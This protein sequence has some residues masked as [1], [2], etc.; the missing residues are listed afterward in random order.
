MIKLKRLCLNLLKIIKMRIKVIYILK[1]VAVCLLTS[2]WSHTPDKN[3][4]EVSKAIVKALDTEVDS[5]EEEKPTI[6]QYVYMDRTGCL[7]LKQNCYSFND[8]DQVILA[9]ETANESSESSLDLKG[10]R[11][12][13][14]RISVKGQLKASDLDYCCCNCINDSIYNILKKEI[15]YS[16]DRSAMTEGAKQIDL[17]KVPPSKRYLYE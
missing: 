13:L 6:G 5:V 10:S 3:E 11:Y 14:H 4:E 2:C 16:D 9:T 12:A 7:H 15:S 17:S 8:N 1:I